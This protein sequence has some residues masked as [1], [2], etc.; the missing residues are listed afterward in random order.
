METLKKVI[1][2]I[3]K[4]QRRESEGIAIFDLMVETFKPFEGKQITK[5]LATALQKVLPDDTI[6]FERQYGMY[7]IR[8]WGNGTPYDQRRS[9]LLGYDTKPVYHEGEYHKKHSG[10]RDF[11]CCYGYAAIERNQQRET[12]L[13]DE[14]RLQKIAKV[15]NDYQAAKKALEGIDNFT[16]PSW[17]SILKEFGLS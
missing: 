14:Q 13:A 16:T 9:F 15:I 1:E 5:R 2:T 17:Y 10:F 11:S 4:D 8:I 3:R 12:L 7:H 6:Y